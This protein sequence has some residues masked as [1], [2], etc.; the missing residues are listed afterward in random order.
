MR[1]WLV[2]AAL[3]GC[4]C[5]WAADEKEAANGGAGAASGAQAPAAVTA[6]PTQSASVVA[7][8][9][10]PEPTLSQDGWFHSGYNDKDYFLNAPMF[11]SKAFVKRHFQAEVPRF[12]LQG[13]VKLQDFVVGDKIELSLKNYLDLVLAN[14]TDIQITKLNIETAKNAIQRAFA[15]F[16][17]NV[18]ARFSTTRSNTPS[19]DALAGASILSQLTQPWTATYNQLLPGGTQ[20]SVGFNGQKLSTNNSFQLYNPSYTA[21]FQMN[22]TQPLLRNR[23]GM[24]N[25]LPVTIAR[26]KLRASQYA[27]QDSVIKLVAGAE[28]AYWAVVE[29][30]ENL[31]VQ[32][33]ALELSDAALKRAQR[34]L[35]LGASS[36]LDI[37]QPQA[38]YANAEIF[39][40]QAKYRLAQ[41]EDA[42]RKQIALDLDPNLRRLPVVL[43][44]AVEPPAPIEMDR[45]AFVERA[46]RARP[47]L[48]VTM[49]QLDI[50][51]LQIKGT[52]NALKPNVLLG[53]GYTSTGRGGPFYRRQNIFQGDGTTSSVLTVLPGGP[54]DALD[55]LFGFGYPI[56]SFSLTVSF[57]IRDRKAAADHA[58]QIVGKKQDLL[59]VRTTEQQVRLDVLN[60]INQVENSKASV[61]LAKIATDL[62]QKRVDAEQKKYEL[63][64]TTIFFVLAA[65]TD[66]T[67]AQSTLVTQTLNYRRNILNLFQRT[68]ELL[69][70][71]NI[72]LR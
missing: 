35:E 37:F 2:I 67:Q 48:R 4:C 28:L 9:R 58:D 19:S 49:Q 39:V 59:T 24:I 65:Q 40:T 38:Q 12:E 53:A 6:G 33:K 60:A 51:D 57:P 18:L 61:Q 66:L 46:L 22:F 44:E 14:N 45:E 8:P 29:A 16:D 68:G 15:V 72:V 21:N 50:D 71:R 62:A 31:R 63:G 7:Q 20:M 10:R 26:S 69:T 34:E 3:C 23:G 5:V 55:Q 54:A 70:E 11:P 43:T 1:S 52:R 30:R 17:P 27:L 36:P 56:Y 13:P 41:A 64:T 42:L 32:E 25:K 47:D